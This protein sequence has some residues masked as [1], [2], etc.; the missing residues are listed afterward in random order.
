MVFSR[1][2]RILWPSRPIFAIIGVLAAGDHGAYQVLFLGQTA[3][4]Y[5]D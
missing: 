4:Q 5:A 3:Q 2:P 1:T